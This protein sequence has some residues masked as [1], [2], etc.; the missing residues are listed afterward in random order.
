MEEYPQ[1]K[2]LTQ[3]EIR[4][5]TNQCWK[6]HLTNQSK[7]PKAAC[8]STQTFKTNQTGH[9]KVGMIPN[10]KMQISQIKTFNLLQ[11]VLKT[12]PHKK[13]LKINLI[14]ILLKIIKIHIKIL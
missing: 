9:L 11:K 8:Q 1:T 14:K 5:P 4:Y 10:Y 2:V 12:E 3:V 13:I 6:T 7:I